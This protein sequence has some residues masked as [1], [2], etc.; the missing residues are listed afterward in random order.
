[1]KNYSKQTE[2]NLVPFEQDM[3]RVYKNPFFYKTCTNLYMVRIYK[4]T[5]M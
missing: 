3:F 1:M 5:I 4:E 2:I